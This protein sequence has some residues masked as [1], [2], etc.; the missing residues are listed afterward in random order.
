[1]LV[2]ALL[3]EERLCDTLGWRERQQAVIDQMFSIL[4]MHRDQAR[5]ASAYLRRGDFC[6]QLGLFAEAD[7]AL[8]ESLTIRRVLADHAGES[9][10]LRSLSF[11]RWHQGDHQEAVS[12][13]KAALAIDRERGDLKAMSHDL[14]NLAPVLQH[15]G[16]FNGALAHLQEALQLEEAQQDAFNRMTI[17]FNIAN[18]Y[19]KSGDLDQALAYYQ[20]SLTVCLQ[21][22]LRINQ[23]L[24][25]CCIAS[26]Y[27]KQEKHEDCLRL[28]REV[29]NISRSMKYGRGLGNGLRALGDFLLQM[30]GQRKPCPISWRA[31]RSLRNL[32]ILIMR[33]SHGVSSR[34]CTKRPIGTIERLLP[35]GTKLGCCE[36]TQATIKVKF[37]QPRK[38]GCWLVITAA[39]H[40]RPCSTFKKRS[41]LLSGWVMAISRVSC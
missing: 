41:I 6:T 14:T 24:V 12:C 29:V 22:H 26:I 4:H 30:G 9:H 19:N 10:A 23:T 8:R 11:L 18:V 32:A 20:E 1:M 27:W 40:R 13:N 34:Q 17:L 38:W 35:R 36:C 16:D 7:R 37:R 2:D 33:R 31:R 28:Y 21:H 5:L 25:L 39:S 3:E 15:L